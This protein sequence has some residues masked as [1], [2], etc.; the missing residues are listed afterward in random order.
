MRMRMRIERDS[1][2]KHEVPFYVYYGIQ[3]QR[4]I[5]N[6][7]ISGYGAHPQLIRAMGMIK[8]AGAIANWELKLIDARRAKAIQTGG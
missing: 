4:A 1:L 6:Y 2:G 7:P 8:K 5:E 3:T